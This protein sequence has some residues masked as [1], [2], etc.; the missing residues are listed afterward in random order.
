MNSRC[1][2]SELVGQFE[3]V[4]S[5]VFLL[6][7]GDDE[8]GQVLCGLDVEASAGSHLNGFAAAWPLDVF[9]VAGEGTGDCQ[10]FAR[11][12]ADVLRQS[13]DPG[14]RTWKTQFMYISALKVGEYRSS[15]F[16]F[17]TKK[18]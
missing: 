15:I 17:G 2:G 14:S 8:G 11:L 16:K 7:P 1:V 13:L 10:D 18:A 5:S 4:A 6:H 9:G 12:D 3:G